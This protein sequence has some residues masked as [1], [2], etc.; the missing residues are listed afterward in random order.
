MPPYHIQSDVFDGFSFGSGCI[1]KVEQLGLIDLWTMQSTRL[2]SKMFPLVFP[3]SAHSVPSGFAWHSTTCGS[4]QVSTGQ[5]FPPNRLKE[6]LPECDATAEQRCYGHRPLLMQSTELP[7]DAAS[8]PCPTVPTYRVQTRYNVQSGR[9]QL[10]QITLKKQS[11]RKCLIDLVEK[12]LTRN[13]QLSCKFPT[14]AQTGPLRSFRA[15]AFRVAGSWQTW[16]SQGDPC[17][18][19]SWGVSPLQLYM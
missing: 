4:S 6:V 18:L 16:G 13:H 7:E 5:V 11:L 10:S 14:A 15:M 8:S 19:D 3:A 2:R 1:L 17:W 12:L 9:G